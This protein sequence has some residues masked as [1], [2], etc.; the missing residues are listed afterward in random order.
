MG[1][2]WGHLRVEGVTEFAVSP[3]KNYSVCVF[4]A[5][6]KGQPAKVQLFNLPDFKNPIAQKSF[7]KADKVTLK[8]N[9]IGTAVLVLTQ[10]E[11]DKT[12]KSYYG[13]TNLYLMA[14]TGNFDCRVSLG[15]ITLDFRMGHC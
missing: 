8:W 12:G 1:I 4:V 2:V 3:G 14:N 5:E 7:Y 9:K 13:E 6:K 15:T 11:V 10:T